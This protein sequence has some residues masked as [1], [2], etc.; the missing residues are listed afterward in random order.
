MPSSVQKN[1]GRNILQ[2]QDW[3]A[4]EVTVC[5]RF[6]ADSEEEVVEKFR[7]WNW[8]NRIEGKEV[9]M[10]KASVVLG[11][12]LWREALSG[13]VEFARWVL[14]VIQ[15]CAVRVGASYT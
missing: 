3:T 7:K 2:V 15:Q 8:K 5:Q 13:L 11:R 1:T 10:G 9:N 12:D 4:W 14:A 6:G